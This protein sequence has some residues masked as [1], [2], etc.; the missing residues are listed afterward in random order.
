MLITRVIT[1]WSHKEV[2]L[3][4]VKVRYNLYNSWLLCANSIFMPGK[5]W[6]HSTKRQK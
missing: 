1:Y 4:I 5:I 6:T 2:I 3:D